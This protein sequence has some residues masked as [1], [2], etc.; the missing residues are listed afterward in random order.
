M[1]AG[2]VSYI[3]RID[4]RESVGIHDPLHSEV[5]FLAAT[6]AKFGMSY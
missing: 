1:Q 6:V 2:V 4:A 5:Y 3:S